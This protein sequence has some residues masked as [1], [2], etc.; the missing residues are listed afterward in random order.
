MPQKCVNFFFVNSC[1]SFE[2]WRFQ[3]GIEI[4]GNN[5]SWSKKI[6]RDH[7]SQWL[8]IGDCDRFFQWSL[9]G[10][11][12]HLLKVIGDRDHFFSDLPQLWP[13]GSLFESSVVLKLSVL[14]I[15]PK[16]SSPPL[17]ILEWRTFIIVVVP[18]QRVHGKSTSRLQSRNIRK[19]HCA[20]NVGI[21]NFIHDES[22]SNLP[23]PNWITRLRYG[24]C[25][26]I[27]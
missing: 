8:L 20:L 24:D 4:L 16:K 3:N 12:D 27:W 19:W 1:F 13:Q 5:W 15:L 2:F 26:R 6:D 14:V 10:D 25:R 22:S 9:I 21:Q 7:F 11:R 17:E 23:A 18:V